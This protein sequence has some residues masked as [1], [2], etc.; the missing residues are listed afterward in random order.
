MDLEVD[1]P[2]EGK[3]SWFPLWVGNVGEV[4]DEGKD[5]PNRVGL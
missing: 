3:T 5:P 1:V 4:E 2:G